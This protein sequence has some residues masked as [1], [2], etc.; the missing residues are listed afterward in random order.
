MTNIVQR[1][2]QRSLAKT[3]EA[4]V[5]ETGLPQDQIVE[6]LNEE[7]NYIP[8]GD[9]SSVDNLNKQIELDRAADNH[10]KQKKVKVSKKA[11]VKTIWDRES[12]KLAEDFK[13]NNEEPV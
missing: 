11:V 6:I 5:N 12:G 7:Y 2:L 3:V 4:L 1:N 9:S 13:G 10:A 8:E